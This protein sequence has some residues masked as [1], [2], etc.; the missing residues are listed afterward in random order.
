MTRRR[1]AGA[2]GGWRPLPDR[3]GHFESGNAAGRRADRR[4]VGELEIEIG[5]RNTLELTE[6]ERFELAG[7]HRGI[8]DQ[9]NRQLIGLQE[10]LRHSLDVHRGD[11]VDAI[12]VGLDLR[13]VQAEEQMRQHL[14]RN[15]AGRF[16]R[17]REIAG[18][19]FL[20]ARSSWGFTG[21]FCSRKNSSTI[22]RS[23]S[24]VADERVSV[25]A[26]MSPLN[27]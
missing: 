24:P 3:C 7:K 15:R 1:G 16:D 2:V 6:A 13:Q 17:Q 18:Q 22:S 20:G 26:T 25:S 21:S 14:L 27:L 9:N 11:A 10:V 8:A 19:E 23:D 5:N 12:A 4:R